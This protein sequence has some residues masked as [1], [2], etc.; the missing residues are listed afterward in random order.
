MFSP[1]EGGVGG[2]G[3]G[4]R[5]VGGWRKGR[6]KGGEGGERE[7]GKEEGVLVMDFPTA[8][9]PQLKPSLTL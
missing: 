3:G 1:G 9:T 2:V 5:K 4:E 7:G 6:W 8:V